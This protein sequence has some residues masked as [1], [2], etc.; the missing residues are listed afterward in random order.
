[1]SLLKTGEARNLYLDLDVTARVPKMRKLSPVQNILS[2]TFVGE[3]V[4]FVQKEGNTRIY[5]WS[6]GPL[7]LLPRPYVGL[8][9]AVVLV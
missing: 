7:W 6:L 8:G 2:S 1:M 9:Y 3:S 4:H 5:S